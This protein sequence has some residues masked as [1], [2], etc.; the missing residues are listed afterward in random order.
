MVFYRPAALS[1]GA[2]QVTS[3]EEMVSK[4]QGTQGAEQAVEQLLEAKKA[5][6]A[7]IAECEKSAMFSARVSDGD[8]R[9]LRFKE[10]KVSD[11]IKK[12]KDKLEGGASAAVI[13]QVRSNATDL[14]KELQELLT[15]QK[16]AF[17]GSAS[18]DSYLD[19]N[20]AALTAINNGPGLGASGEGGIPVAKPMGVGTIVHAAGVL[21]DGLIMTNVGQLGE[22]F[23]KVFAAKAHGAWHIHQAASV[24]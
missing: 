20:M 13:Q 9:E 8:E 23:S 17:S 3:I 7:V 16:R 12:L 10:S 6:Q 2:E 21:S 1:D 22:K 18:G 14:V 11:T 15:Q 5:L 24:L 4:L 19:A